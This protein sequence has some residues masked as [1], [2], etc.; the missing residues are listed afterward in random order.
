MAS[1]CLAVELEPSDLQP[2]NHFAKPGQ[3]AHLGGDNDSEVRLAFGCGKVFGLVVFPAS[4]Y[5]LPRDIAGDFQSLGDR[6]PLGDE[7]LEFM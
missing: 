7:A 3:A 1:R 2:A 4:L 5:Q 6:T